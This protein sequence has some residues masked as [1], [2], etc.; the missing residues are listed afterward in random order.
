MTAHYEF[1]PSNVFPHWIVFTRDRE[2]DDVLAIDDNWLRENIG[3]GS[4]HS[5]QHRHQRWFA[6]KEIIP[7][8]KMSGFTKSPAIHSVRFR[9]EK[10][11][12]FYLLSGNFTKEI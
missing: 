2:H 11:A 6:Y 1:Q 7:I 12:L 4:Y 10:D 8:R 9:D 5:G 3:L